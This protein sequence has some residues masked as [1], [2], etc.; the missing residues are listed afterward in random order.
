MFPRIL[1]TLD[2]GEQDRELV[3]AETGDRVVARSTR[4]RRSADLLQQL[5]ARRVAERVVHDLEAIEVDV[6]H[7]DALAAALAYCEACCT[8][9]WKRKRFG[10]PVRLSR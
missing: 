5:V 3:P 1:G 6:H 10:R 2:L 4:A 8:R 7:R 9:S